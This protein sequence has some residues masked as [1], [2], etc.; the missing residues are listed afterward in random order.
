MPLKEFEQ[1]VEFSFNVK[2]ECFVV[3]FLD[4]SSYAITTS[5]LP[6]KMQT[7]KP[8]WGDA[9]LS[10]DKSS[11]LVQAGDELRLI[12]SHIIHSKGKLL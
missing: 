12:Q 8:A 10:H 4:G 5:D 2:T 9:T 6:K 1:I 7:K 11:I 3:R